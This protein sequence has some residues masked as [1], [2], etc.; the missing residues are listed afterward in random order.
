MHMTSWLVKKFFNTEGNNYFLTTLLYNEDLINTT[1]IKLILH[2][3]VT[4]HE[5]HIIGG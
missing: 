5:F 4:N 2:L 3:Q 1:T